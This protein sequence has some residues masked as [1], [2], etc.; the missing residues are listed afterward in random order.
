MLFMFMY[1][2]YKVKIIH[3]FGQIIDLTEESGEITVLSLA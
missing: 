1:F 2:I 3:N